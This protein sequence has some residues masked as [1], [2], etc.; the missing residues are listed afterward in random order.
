MRVA[1][2]ILLIPAHSPQ[3][4]LLGALLGLADDSGVPSCS[5]V[6]LVGELQVGVLAILLDQ[7]IPLGPSIE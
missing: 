5:M 1:S 4:S 2:T 7:G 6:V 3:R